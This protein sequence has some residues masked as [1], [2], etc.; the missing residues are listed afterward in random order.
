MLSWR[1]SN[2]LAVMPSSSSKHSLSINTKRRDLPACN[3]NCNCRNQ[4]S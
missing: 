2:K 4:H 1:V 3:C